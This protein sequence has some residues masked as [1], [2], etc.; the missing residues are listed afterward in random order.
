M[1]MWLAR[2]IFTYAQFLIGKSLEDRPES[3]NI[4]CAAAKNG[5]LSFRK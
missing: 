4:S 3:R 1:W 2:T 5:I